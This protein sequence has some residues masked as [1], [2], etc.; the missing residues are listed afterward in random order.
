MSTICQF[1]CFALI[2]KVGSSC[3][4]QREQI[5]QLTASGELQ[6]DEY[7]AIAYGYTP[8]TW[9]AL[10]YQPLNDFYVPGNLNRNTNLNGN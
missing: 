1:L 5:E 3:D 4:G 2:L 7:L 6:S 8:K 9:K 10:S